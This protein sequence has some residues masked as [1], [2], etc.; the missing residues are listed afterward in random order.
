MYIFNPHSKTRS[1]H[2]G[3][4][5]LL[6]RQQQQTAVA[7]QIQAQGI[8]TVAPV[9]PRPTAVTLAALRMGWG[10]DGRLKWL[11]NLRVF[12]VF[13][14]KICQDGFQFMGH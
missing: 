14:V 9:V 11:K 10:W 7:R 12:D 6:R 2:L 13:V 8:A 4:S 1:N 3:F 5:K